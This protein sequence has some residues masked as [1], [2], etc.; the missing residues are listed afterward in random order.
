MSGPCRGPLLLA[1]S[2]SAGR[3]PPLFTACEHCLSGWE[4]LCA[5]QQNTGYSGPGSYAE[6]VLADSAYVGHPLWPLPLIA[7]LYA[8]AG[9]LMVIVSAGQLSARQ[10][11][12]LSFFF[13]PVLY[14][15]C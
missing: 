15:S 14:D 2:R 5:A 9:L 10:G 13:N 8:R 1:C 3:G 7:T 11:P 12:R 6:Y 4:T